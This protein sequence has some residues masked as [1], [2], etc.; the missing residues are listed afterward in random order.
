M[1]Y[2]NLIK[3]VENFGKREKYFQRKKKKDLAK[4]L[5]KGEK[6]VKKRREYNLKW[7]QK[8]PK[9]KKKEIKN[10]IINKGTHLEG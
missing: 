1:I 5:G 3:K 7:L 10:N 9:R 4:S 2:N 8:R 6:M